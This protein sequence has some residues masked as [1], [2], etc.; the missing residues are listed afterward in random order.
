MEVE[1]VVNV[2]QGQAELELWR[3]YLYIM[4][5]VS[6]CTPTP[7][8]QYVW[9]AEKCKMR[10]DKALSWKTQPQEFNT[11]CSTSRAK[12]SMCLQI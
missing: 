11:L 10:R 7:H 2:D 6:Q 4:V 5:K 12:S 9:V 3:T 8:S 1:E